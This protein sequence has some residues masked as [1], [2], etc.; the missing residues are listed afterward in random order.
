MMTQIARVLFINNKLWSNFNKY[1]LDNKSPR[2]SGYL[3]N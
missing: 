1:L 3:L 2:F